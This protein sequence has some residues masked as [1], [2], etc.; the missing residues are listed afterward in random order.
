MKMFRKDKAYDDKVDQLFQRMVDM[1][2]HHFHGEVPYP[3][4]A[5]VFITDQFNRFKMPIDNSI[6]D[7]L[8]YANASIVYMVAYYNPYVM[9]DEFSDV[10]F[11]DDWSKYTYEVFD[12]GSVAR[13]TDPESTETY[14]FIPGQAE[15]FYEEHYNKPGLNNLPM[16]LS[17]SIRDAGT[18]IMD[19]LDYE[20]IFSGVF[21][22]K[23]SPSVYS[24]FH[25]LE[26]FCKDVGYDDPLQVSQYYLD[27]ALWAAALWFFGPYGR[28][29]RSSLCDITSIALSQGE[30]LLCYGEAISPN[31][32]RRL[33]RATYSCYLCGVDAWC[34]EPTLDDS[35]S[36]RYICEGC[37]SEGIDGLFAGATCGTRY[38]KYFECPHNLY[39]HHGDNAVREGL[40]HTGQLHSRRNNQNAL[41]AKE[42][43]KRLLG[44]KP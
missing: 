29:Y 34:V 39:S 35:G 7:L 28:A 14:K 33:E 18:D 32:F 41:K 10:T 17:G 23:N 30:C 9:F 15:R 4:N 43:S 3:D 22:E 37:S 38:C 40:K 13:E 6:K 20:D 5:D 42:E 25:R 11:T 12:E 19:R 24:M 27:V 44:V 8:L 16:S 2:T 21:V 31:Y 26:E 1:G 36:L